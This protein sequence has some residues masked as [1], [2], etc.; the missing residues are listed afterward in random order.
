MFRVKLSSV[1][2]KQFK[3]LPKEIRERIVGAL[4]RTRIRPKKFFEKL[5]DSELY[6]L[7]V[8]AYRIIAKIKNKELII[9]VINVDHRKRIYK[10]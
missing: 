2:K 10:R 3:K 8:G 4:E 5:Q 9:L 7:R 1:A 6:K